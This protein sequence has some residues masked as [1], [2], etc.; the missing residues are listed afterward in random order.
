MLPNLRPSARKNLRRLA[1][2]RPRQPLE[3]H[4]P[5]PWLLRACA[6]MSAAV[7]CAVIG[8]VPTLAALDLPGVQ[9]RIAAG[10]VLL[11]LFTALLAWLAVQFRPT[12]VVL[13]DPEEEGRP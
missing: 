8:A 7:L 10:I 11:G 2:G 1:Y 13:R 3:P 9:D 6:W 4:R 12:P 5:G